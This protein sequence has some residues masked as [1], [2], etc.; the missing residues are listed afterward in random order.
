MSSLRAIIVP[1]NGCSGNIRGCNWYGFAQ[2]K[3]L[4]SGLFSEVILEVMPDPYEAKE[5]IWIP[6]LLPK[7]RADKDTIIFG[8]SSGAEACMRLLE[9]NRLAGAV[10]VAACHTDLGEPSETISGYYSRPWDWA[11][12]RSNV[13][14]S[15]GILQVHSK[16]DPFIPPS[17]ATHVADSLQS[18]FHLFEDRSHFFDAEAIDSVLDM[19]LDKITRRQPSPSSSP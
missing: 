16:D 8:H 11:S 7:H 14:P 12:I 1:G 6:H 19:A 3:L 17:E 18:D 15:F 9:T 10:L 5:S 4:A 13:D 2:D